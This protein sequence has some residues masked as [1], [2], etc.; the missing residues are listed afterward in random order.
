LVDADKASLA[1]AEERIKNAGFTGTATFWNADVNKQ[2]AAILADVPNHSLNIAFVDP[3]SLDVHFDTV[4]TIAS[5]RA[6]DLVVLFSDRIDLGRNVGSTYYSQSNSKLDKF[7]GA[8]SGW[9]SRY[10][11]MPDRSGPKIRQLFADIYC[12]QL[13]A[14]GYGHRKTWPI[15]GPQGPMFRLVYASKVDLGLKFCEVALNEEFGGEKGL[16]G[17]M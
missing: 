4:A 17:G 5:R 15:D 7:L 11:S 1:A 12:E 9:R 2:I 3:Y 14:I 13:K 16:F 8:R 10:D 6:M